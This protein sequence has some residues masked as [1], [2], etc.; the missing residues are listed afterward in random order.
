[1]QRSR[2]TL[3]LFIAAIG[4]A[5]G[6]IAAVPATSIP[7]GEPSGL[8]GRWDFDDATGKDLSG[9]GADAI[10]GAT[11]IYPLGAGHACVEILPGDE[12]LRIPAS[13]DSP[14]AIS[15]GTVCLWLN[16]AWLDSPNVLEY[17]NGAVEFRIYRRH[18]QPRFK[19]QDDFEY[20]S[21]ILDYDWPKYDMREWAFYPHVR[22]AVGDSEWHH[23]AVAYDDQAKRIIGWRDGELIAAVDLSTVAMKPLVREGL[24]EIVAGNSFA[25]FID[26]IRIYN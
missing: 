25:G 14:L 16:M 19:G 26:D 2:V 8:A 5:G 9:H 3:V 6:S 18:L 7:A 24:K 4:A 23:F 22:A 13:P 11:R 15:H 21:S 1:M 20:S 12:P 10:L 17:S